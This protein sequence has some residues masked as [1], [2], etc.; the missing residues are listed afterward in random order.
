MV[1]SAGCFEFSKRTFSAKNVVSR[2]FWR[3]NF[4]VME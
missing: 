1:N 3:S 2:D 4:S